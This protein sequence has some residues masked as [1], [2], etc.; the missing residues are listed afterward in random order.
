MAKKASKRSIPTWGR[1]QAALEADHAAL[2]AYSAD[3]PLGNND[4]TVRYG[5]MLGGMPNVPRMARGPM[6]Q[7][8]GKYS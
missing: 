4:A 3:V 1:S 7:Y 5:T 2:H 8:R 6:R